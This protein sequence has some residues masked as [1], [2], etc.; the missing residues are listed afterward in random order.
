MSAK[1]W[2]IGIVV[3][4]IAGAWWYNTQ[5]SLVGMSDGIYDCNAVYVNADDK[6]QIIERGGQTF[7]G[8]LTVSNGKVTRLSEPAI[9]GWVDKNDLVYK[10]KGRKRVRV[11]DSKTYESNHYA[12]AC[13]RQ[14]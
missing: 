4:V 3:V 9:L 1:A 7:E 10:T 2:I 12:L 6:Y 11:T 14:E 8:S 5:S 13:E